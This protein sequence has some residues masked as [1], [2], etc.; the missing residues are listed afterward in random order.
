MTRTHT[1]RAN[2]LADDEAGRWRWQMPPPAPPAD[3]GSRFPGA[4][5]RSTDERKSRHSFKIELSP[6]SHNGNMLRCERGTYQP[7]SSAEPAEQAYVASK[8]PA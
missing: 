4:G 6:K 7:A 2:A 8:K 5:P 1:R 3:A